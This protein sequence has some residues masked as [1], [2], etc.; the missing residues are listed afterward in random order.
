MTRNHHYV[1]EKL[2]M[3]ENKSSFVFSFWS[4]LEAL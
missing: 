1:P 2:M 4:T 3:E